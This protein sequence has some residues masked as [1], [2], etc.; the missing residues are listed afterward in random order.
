MNSNLKIYI[1]FLSVLFVKPICSMNLLAAILAL[2]AG[3]VTISPS[4]TG[5]HDAALKGDI[6]QVK[7]YLEQGE[8]VNK[9]ENDATPLFLALNKADK[10][11]RE[12]A[13]LLIQKG[14]DVNV[15][16]ECGCSLLI[17]SITKEEGCPVDTLIKHKEIKINEVSCKK[18]LTP[19][20]VAVV[21]KNIHALKSLIVHPDVDLFAKNL[22]GKTAIQ[23]A[24][25]LRNPDVIKLLEKAL[26]FKG[27]K[28]G[29]ID[30]V[31]KHIDKLYTA[32]QLNSIL[33]YE[34]K[35]KLD[36]D[37]SCEFCRKSQNE[38]RYL[39]ACMG[40]QKVFY[41]NRTCQSKDWKWHKVNCN[42]NKQA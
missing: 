6:E 1:L 11:Q 20:M 31:K 28:L 27:L 32:Q 40:C 35:E 9:V 2:N 10:N 26:M 12:I 41:C 33:P 18:G 24:Q 16:H 29:L 13:E 38:Q 14:A 4:H 36:L 17:N 37:I 5:I 34:I 15:K 8:D 19:L 30:Y 22:M 42:N 7:L 39:K 23:I 25:D 21:K 3:T